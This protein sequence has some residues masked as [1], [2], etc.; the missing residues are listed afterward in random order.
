MKKIKLIIAIVFAINISGV[1]Q[2]EALSRGECRTCRG[3]GQ[4]H[5]SHECGA[6]SGGQQRCSNCRGNGEYTCGQCGGGGS[7]T[8]YGEAQTCNLCGG[9]GNQ[10][11]GSCGGAGS[12]ECNFCG[13]S[14]SIDA[15]FPCNACGGSG[16]N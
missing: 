1:A 16:E 12:N 4:T 10:T 15:Y 5:L 8:V 9:S 6:C 7:V 14:G 2:S 11:C 3:T 13:G